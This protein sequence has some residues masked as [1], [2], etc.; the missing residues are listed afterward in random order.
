MGEEQALL[1][2]IN[3]ISAP[4]MYIRDLYITHVQLSS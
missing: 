3:E 2:V 4:Q 1:T